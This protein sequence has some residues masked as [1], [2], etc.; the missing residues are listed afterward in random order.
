MSDVYLDYINRAISNVKRV[1]EETNGEYTIIVTAD[2]G[3]HDRAHGSD[4]YEDMTI[5]MFF[6]G[7][8]FAP[9]R[10]FSG[11]SI[12]DI[13]PTIADIIGVVPAREWEGKSLVGD[14]NV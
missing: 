9:G 5:P 1:I 13:A 7:P 10:E 2:H 6:Y 4:R 8:Q 12:L 14:E 3:G 11:G